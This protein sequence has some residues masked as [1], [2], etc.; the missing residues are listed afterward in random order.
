METTMVIE[1]VDTENDYIINRI[2]EKL[3][4]LRKNQDLE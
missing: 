3:V 2:T 1:S 4:D